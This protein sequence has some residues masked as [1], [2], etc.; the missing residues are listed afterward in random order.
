MVRLEAGV[1]EAK[2][3]TVTLD[4]T[5]E[6]YL[7]DCEAR[8][9]KPNS[10]RGYQNALTIFSAWCKQ[11]NISLADLSVE[12]FSDYRAFRASLSP[13]AQTT[14][15][16]ILRMWCQYCVEREWMKKNHA[17]S[18][19]CPKQTAVPT[20]PY[21]RDEIAA[22]L[23]NCNKLPDCDR[24]WALVLTL[25]YSGLRISDAI[26]LERTK[27]QSD[28]R[29]F[30]RM[31]K[32][33]HPVYVR[34]PEECTSALNALAMTGAHFFW[35]KAHHKLDS[36]L[37]LTRK[38]IF[39]LGLVAGVEHAHPHRFRD[40]FAVELLVAGEDIRTVQM[41]LGH[42]SLRTTEKHYA[43]WVQAMQHKLDTATSKLKFTTDVVTQNPRI[44][45]LSGIR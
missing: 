19:K 44:E 13:S 37:S 23:S 33:G 31:E 16:V 11:R 17:K 10:L 21:S 45:S 14:E 34:L 30:L 2:P 6:S 38:A 18:I 39:Q 42:T 20:M 32:T 7:K 35:D 3:V 43:P 24:L 9:I 12:A 15:I 29:L 4:S 28:G 26:Q 25:L 40:T 1:V 22:L 36:E 8:H 5:V 41:L 27:L